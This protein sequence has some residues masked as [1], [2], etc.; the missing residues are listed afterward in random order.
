MADHPGA[1]WIALDV[2][3]ADEQI[4]FGLDKI[5]KEASFPERTA[6]RVN[7][8]EILNIRL[9]QKFHHLRDPA[10]L[11]RRREQV[12]V[13]RHQHIGVD[14]DFLFPRNRREPIQIPDTVLI[15]PEAWAAIVATLDD[16]EGESGDLNA[17]ATRHFF[18]LFWPRTVMLTTPRHPSKL[19]G[20]GQVMKS[21]GV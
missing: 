19:E 9:T 18:S 21:I 12:D 1:H 10:R 6:P 8:I 2:T 3:V 20:G 11:S 5:G 7:P 16:V 17:W 4:A 15:G 13:V 14:V